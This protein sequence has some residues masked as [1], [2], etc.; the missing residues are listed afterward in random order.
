MFLVDKKFRVTGIAVFTFQSDHLQQGINSHPQWKLCLNV[1]LMPIDEHITWASPEGFALLK[2]PADGFHQIVIAPRGVAVLAALTAPLH[3]AAGLD[4][5]GPRLKTIQNLS[6]WAE[7]V[8]LA[9]ISMT[10]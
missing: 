8:K 4:I 3:A 10:G 6:G 5:Y 7:V 1:G 2:L 9:K